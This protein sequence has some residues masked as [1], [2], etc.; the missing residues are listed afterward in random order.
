MGAHSSMDQDENW[1][2]YPL[3]REEEA[4]EED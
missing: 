2:H 1:Q 3:Q 4:L